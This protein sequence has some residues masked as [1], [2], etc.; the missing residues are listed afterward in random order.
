MSES[1][2]V[3]KMVDIG[4]T[5]LRLRCAGH[6]APTVVLESG[7]GE[8]ADTWTKVQAQVAGFTRVCAYDRAGVGESSPGPKPRT[9]R[10]MVGELRALLSAAQ[11][12]GPYVL[13]G[14]SLGGLNVQLFAIEHPDEV[15]GLVLVDSSTPDLLARLTDVWGK[16]RVSLFKTLAT[17]SDA[18]G[19]S[20]RDF[21]TSFVQVAAAGKLPDVP[22]IVI[23]AGQAV[24]LP[25]LLNAVFPG[26]R[27][28]SAFQAGHAEL[29][30]ASSQGQ[31]LFAAHSTHATISQDDLVVDAIRQVVDM[32]H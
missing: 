26:D 30:R 23:S 1:A 21:E 25:G 13:V 11:I 2:L 24:E 29:A 27:W 6:G 10:Q 28:L 17:A 19:A 31:Q 32:L 14:H 9:S 20:K 18:E 22:L 5:Q 4:S 3:E 12:D 8:G 15:V 7:L 16:F